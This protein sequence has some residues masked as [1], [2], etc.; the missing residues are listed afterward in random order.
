MYLPPLSNFGHKEIGVSC[1]TIRSPHVISFWKYDRHKQIF[2]NKLQNRPPETPCEN[3][4][5][6]LNREAM[7]VPPGLKCLPPPIYWPLDI[8]LSGDSIQNTGT[9]VPL[10]T[11]NTTNINAFVKETGP[12]WIW[13]KWRFGML[14]EARL[15]GWLDISWLDI[16]RLTKWW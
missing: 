10:N 16:V 11:L 4:V 13:T 14:T 7:F 2:R 5:W 12:D 8:G 15:S 6:C 3:L 1:L 9:R